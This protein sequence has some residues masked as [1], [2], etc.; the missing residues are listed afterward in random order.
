MMSQLPFSKPVRISEQSW[1]VSTIP[2]VSICCI[3]YNHGQFIR[4]ALEGFLM[5]ETTFPVEIVIRDDASEDDTRCIIVDYVARHKGLF[6][7][8]FH[9]ENQYSLGRKPFPEVFALA[10]G[11][12]IAVCE[13][14]DYWID[15]RKL[16]R[17]VEFLRANPRYPFCFH[18][19]LARDEEKRVILPDALGSPGRRDEY[20]LDDLLKSNFVATPS[21]VFRNNP[22]LVIPDWYGDCPFG[23]LPLHLLNLCRSSHETFGCLRGEM[24]VYRRH[25]GGMYQGAP[26]MLNVERLDLTYRL[27]AENLGLCGR[28]SFRMGLAN[29]EIARC[30]AHQKSRN[31]IG[32]LK[33][34]IAA[35]R[36]APLT[37]LFKVGVRAFW[38]TVPRRFKKVLGWAG[39]RW[40]A[41]RAS[42]SGARTC[43]SRRYL[44]A[45]ESNVRLPCRRCRVNLQ[46]LDGDW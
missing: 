42:G 3:T 25:G 43:G 44:D 36:I 46:K 1:P 24:A 34:G 6:T 27:A 11:E 28:P 13:G 35:C 15:P 23:D 16:E 8:L 2:L 39:K 26:A 5:Q 40:R 29:V 38:A 9:T 21:V 14:D 20:H 17:Q 30:E 41:L 10:K 19:I 7:T 4:D 12:F 45:L 37:G 31:Y 18:P 33:A 32:A 22:R